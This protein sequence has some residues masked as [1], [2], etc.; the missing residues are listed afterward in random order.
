M[1]FNKKEFA[2]RLSQ[3]YSRNYTDVPSKEL[4]Q[5]FMDGLIHALFPVRQNCALDEGEI[6]IE[7]DRAAVKLK[8][9]LYSI[10]KSLDQNP[11]DLVEAFFSRVPEA[12]EMLAKDAD[13]VMRFDPAATCVEEI[14]LCYPGFYAITVYRMAHIL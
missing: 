5:Q 7:L 2:S 8:E 1:T 6:A 12:F 14:I 13:S 3:F 10:R 4:S 9:L 11:D